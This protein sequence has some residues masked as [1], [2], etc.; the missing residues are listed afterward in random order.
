MPL[1]KSTGNMYDFVTHT[2]NTVKGECPH[3]CSYCYMN[4]WGKQPD[5][6]F[7]EKELNT[8]LGSSNVIFVGSSC[9][10]FAEEIERDWILKTLTKC[11]SHDNA[12]LF[13][14]KNPIKMHL[15][16]CKYPEKTKL[17]TT[18]ETNRWYRG[19]MRSAP[20][21]LKRAEA[22]SI[23]HQQGFKT[24]VTIEPILDFDLFPMLELIKC[25]EP[26]QVNI[27][28]YTGNKVLPEPSSEKVQILID[29]ISQYGIPVVKKDNLK[30]IL[31]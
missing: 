22:M 3:S 20:S 19:I 18:I 13:Q 9:D 11:N 2:W 12:Y 23:L 7:D 17:G 29:E 24:F 1:N 6:H 26:T 30:R 5:L 8:N 14:S 27:G 4:R 31:K 21:P 28:A 10:M 25:C 15:F 16:S